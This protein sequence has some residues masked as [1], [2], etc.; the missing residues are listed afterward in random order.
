[1][2]GWRARRRGRSSMIEMGMRKAICLSMGRPR[3]SS[4]STASPLFTITVK[5]AQAALPRRYVTMRPSGRR[6]ETKKK[7]HLH[8]ILACAGINERRYN[9]SAIKQ[10]G[11]ENGSVGNILHLFRKSQFGSKLAAMYTDIIPAKV[12]T[13]VPGKK[14]SSRSYD[15]PN[16]FEGKDVRR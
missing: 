8:I 15:V 6:R 4:L 12:E 7:R 14:T 16:L 11:L 2:T 9:Q 3:Q 5:S 10:R 13:V 1:M